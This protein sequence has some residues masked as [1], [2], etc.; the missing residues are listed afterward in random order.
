MLRRHTELNRATV[1][2]EYRCI[3]PPE[4]EGGGLRR[5]TVFVPTT[6]SVVFVLTPNTHMQLAGN[7]NVAQMLGA[8]RTYRGIGFPGDTSVP[9]T[10]GADQALWAASAEGIAEVGLLIEFVGG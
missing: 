1:T 9:F 6:P 8:N 5:V 4:G 3:L 10:L 2:Q 7:A